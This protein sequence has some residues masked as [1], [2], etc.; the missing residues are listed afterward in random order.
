M[1]YAGWRALGGGVLC[2]A[3]VSLMWAGCRSG[4]GGTLPPHGTAPEWPLSADPTIQ[5]QLEAR[6]QQLNW[7]ISTRLAVTGEVGAGRL[8]LFEGASAFREIDRVKDRLGE[9]VRRDLPGKTE[10]EQL[11]R[12]VIS[13]VSDALSG[14]PERAQVVGRLENELEEHLRRHA[15]AVQLPEFRR[16][17]EVPWLE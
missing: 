17:T 10:G 7:A 16:P 5:E 4:A 8:T 6:Q 13:F 12:R 14:S 1:K 2:V 9:L 15:G 11:C 3:G